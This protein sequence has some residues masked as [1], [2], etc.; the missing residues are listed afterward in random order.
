MQGWGGYTR[1]N[2][3]GSGL[4]NTQSA[5]VSSAKWRE[6]GSCQIL[7]PLIPNTQKNLSTNMHAKPK[8]SQNKNAEVSPS[9]QHSSPPSSTNHLPLP[10]SFSCS[11]HFFYLFLLLGSC[12]TWRPIGTSNWYGVSRGYVFDLFYF[13][14]PCKF[15]IS[16]VMTGVLDDTFLATLKYFLQIQFFFF[17]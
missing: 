8:F 16:N 6:S 1:H 2:M 10:K 15:S 13:L 14:I 9:S 12:T 7:T 4:C 3:Q 11:L 5:W 17:I